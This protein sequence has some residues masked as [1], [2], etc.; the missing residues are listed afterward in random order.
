[1]N[2]IEINQAAPTGAD[3]P[4]ALA[5]RERLRSLLAAR[6]AALAAAP[7]TIEALRREAGDVVRVGGFDE[8]ILAYAMVLLDGELQRD[9][10]AKVPFSRRLLLLP[11]CL[12]NL[13]C[14][15]VVDELGLVCKRC[16]NCLV[17][18]FVA[19]ADT[20][21]YVTLVAEGSATV[22]RLIQTGQVQGIVGVSCLDSLEQVFPYIRA[23]GVPAVAIPLLRDGCSQT[24][25]DEEWVIDA[26]MLSQEGGRD[27]DFSQLRG[28]CESLFTESR[29]DE[30]LGEPAGETSRMARAVLL[31]GGKRHRPLLAMA[32]YDA[33]RDGDELQPLPEDVLLAA[34]AVECFH[35]ASLVHDDIEDGDVLRD[36]R[37]TVCAR[38]TMPVALNIGDALLGLGYRILSRLDAA[39]ELVAVAADAHERLAEGQGAELLARRDGLCPSLDM[40]QQ[41]ARNKTSPAFEVAMRL[42]AIVAGADADVAQGINEFAA[43]TGEAYQL[44]DD[45]IDVVGADALN[46]AVAIREQIGSGDDCR[47]LQKAVF[48][49]L[50]RLRDRAMA[51]AQ[52]VDSPQLRRLMQRALA[53]LLLDMHQMECCRDE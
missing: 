34:V 27:V 22:M 26:L 10:L 18:Q 13:D 51:A 14:Q 41:T 30:L 23:A 49:E 3:V 17:G 12:R 42:G 25:V 38:E 44:R 45:W 31:D 43:A 33:L 20:L 19:A 4:A 52:T 50:G 16:E 8:G 32:T 48:A 11:K 6:A 1:M 35:K 9:A 2:S 53:R 15:A 36:G 40:L 24:T 37:E 47:A 28:E 39:T 21:G 5:D 7:Q 29:L 46:M